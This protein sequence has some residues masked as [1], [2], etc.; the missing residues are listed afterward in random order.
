MNKYAAAALALPLG[1][2]EFAI[3]FELENYCSRYARR[4][5][6]FINTPSTPNPFE[7]IKDMY[8]LIVS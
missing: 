2:Y 7:C 5:P 4:N 6:N 8:E 3:E 1:I